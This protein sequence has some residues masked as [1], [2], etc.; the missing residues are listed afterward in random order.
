MNHSTDLINLLATYRHRDAAK[1]D[2]EKALQAFH[3][4]RLK[5]QDYTSDNG[6]TSRL[7]CLDGTIPVVYEGNT[8]NIPL[9]VYFIHQHPYYPPIAY[10]RPTLNMQIKPSQNVDTSGKIFLPYLTEWKYPGSSTQKLLEILQGVFGARTPVFSKP[11][12]AQNPPVSYGFNPQISAAA[13]PSTTNGTVF[14][15]P[16]AGWGAMPRLPSASSSSTP[17]CT[18]QASYFG[19]AAMPSLP[20]ATSSTYLGNATPSTGSLVTTQYRPGLMSEEEQLLMSLRSAVVDRLNKEYRELSEVLNCEIQSLQATESDLLQRGNKIETIHAS[21]ASE[22]DQV[23]SLTRE[24]KDK[25]REYKEAYRKLEQ[26]ANGNVD[27][28]SVVD[29]TTPV[30]KQ[31]VEAFADEQA[32][33]DVLY[34]LSQALENGAIDP[35]EFLKAVRDQSRNQFMKRAMVFQC[36]AKAGLPSV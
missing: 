30:Y 26:E 11:K 14:G 28:D 29:T 23:R 1:S 19:A 9:A 35:D 21:M 5:I 12:V 31:L 15:V 36:R 17:N 4:L 3:S 7:A 27:Y 10:V 6:Q 32:I 34:Y 25:T 16:G 13:T 24:L 8:Y 22:L 2:I 20:S 18:S 33:G